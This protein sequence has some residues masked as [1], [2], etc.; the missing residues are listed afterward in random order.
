L[1]SSARVSITSSSG[2]AEIEVDGAFVGDT[3]TALQ[4]ATGQHRIVVRSGT[5]SWQRTLQ[6]NA[7]SS[8]SL[9]ASLQ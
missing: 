5:K 9:N 3:P 8:I 2:T 4:L 6:V 7:G 1:G